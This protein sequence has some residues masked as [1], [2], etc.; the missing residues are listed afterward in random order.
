MAI[1]IKFL[2]L[3][4]TQIITLINKQIADKSHKLSPFLA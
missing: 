2:D 1:T 4:G 3:V